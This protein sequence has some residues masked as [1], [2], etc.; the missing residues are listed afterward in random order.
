[1]DKEENILNGIESQ[2][3]SPQFKTLFYKEDGKYKRLGMKSKGNLQIKN[4]FDIVISLLSYCDRDILKSIIFVLFAFVSVSGF[5]Q[6]VGDYRNNGN[7][8]WGTLAT[9]QRWNGGAWQ[10]PTAGQ[11]YPGQ[12]TGTGTVIIEN[13]SNVTLNITPTYSINNLVLETGNR[14]TFIRFNGTNSL[15]V[16]GTTTIERPT[17]NNRYKYIDVL[18]G[19][20]T[21]GSIIIE[22]G[23]NNGRDSY[24]Q[25]SSGTVNVSGDVAMYGSNLRNYFLFSGNGTLN[26][27]GNMS[28]GTITN[29]M[30]GGTNPPNSG[31][32]NYN[33]TGAQSVGDYTY[34]NLTISGGNTKTIQGNVTVNNNLNLLNGNLSLGAG[35]N[36]ITIADGATLSGAFDNN[37][38]I[39]CNGNG[40]LIK[41]GNTGTDFE[42]VYPVGTG[43]SY[44]PFEITSM[45]SSGTGNVSVRTVGS[46]EPNANASDL[47]RYWTVNNT[48]TVTSANVSFGYANPGDVGSGDQ[49]TYI[50]YFYNGGWTIPDGI[51]AEGA[52]P[53]TVTGTNTIAGNWTSREA[54]NITTYYTYQSGNWNTAATWTTDPSGTLSVNPSVPDPDDRAIILNGR[55][56]SINS[57]SVSILSLQINEGGTLDI[58]ATTGHNFGDVRG[59]GLLRL[60]SNIFPSGSF[61]EFVSNNGGTV[62]YYNT[63]NF[64]LG[65]YTYNNLTLNLSNTG[66]I[67]TVLNNLT[68][69]GNLTI[70]QGTFR[71][72]SNT[73][74]TRLDLT[75][76][77]NVLVQTNGRISTGSGNVGSAHRFVVRGDFTNNGQ[78]RFSNLAAPDYLN[79]PDDRVDV[80]FDNGA[81][82]QNVV[83]N[84]RTEFYRIEINKGIDQTFV[85]NI[86]ATATNHFYLFGTNNN[87]GVTPSPDAPNIN[88]LNALGLMTGTVRLGP[89]IVLPSLAEESASGQDLNYHV[90]EDACLWIDGANVTHTTN[91]NGGNSNSFVLYGKLK[92][93]NPS[94]SLN[95]NN[96]HGI[97]LRANAA[98]HIENGTLTA[99]CIRTSTVAGT[100]R[101]SY[102]Q[103]GGTV[104][105][106]GNITGANRHPSFSMTW[107]A[108]GFVMS[109]GNLTI[110]QAT[111]GGD[112][113]EMSMV[114]GANEENISVTGGTVQFDIRNRNACFATTAP[115]WNLIINDASGASFTCMNRDYAVGT[116]VTDA[117]S[118]N[119]Q[120]LVVLNDFIIAN[121][122]TFI[123]NDEN[124]TLGRNF[125][126][127]ASATY[128]PGNNTTTFNGNKG[129]EFQNNGAIATGLFNLAIVENSNTSI[130]QNLE[131][132][133]NLTIEN[134]SFLQDMGRTISV[135]GN[136]VNSGTHTSQ[137]GGGIQL[138]GTT[139]Q[140]IGGSGSGVF[141]N[142]II[143]KSAGLASFT[144][145]QSLTGNLRLANGMLDIGMYNLS[146]G[147]ISN[148]YDALTG[149]TA[150]FSG[151]KMIRSSGN[152]S[153]GGLTKEYSSTGAFIFPIGTAS[154]Y[155]PATIQ[156]NAAPTTWGSVNVRPVAQYNPFVTSTNSLDYYWK[157]KQTGFTGIQANSVSHTFRYVD[158]DL[159]GRGNEANYVPGVYNPFS[160]AYINDISQVVDA[161]NDIRFNNVSYV[162]GDYTAG[163]LSAFQPITVF[164]SRQDG[165]WN[166][167]NTWST[168]AVGGAACPPGAVPGVNIPGPS[169]PVVIGDS[170]VVDHV[171]TVPVG[172]NNITIGG[173]QL[174]IGSTLDIT[175]TTGHNFGAIPDSK[176]SGS[177]LLK[178]SSALATAA[179][180]GGDFGNF[181]NSGGGSVEY[182]NTGVNFTLPV[183]PA[184]Y[185]NLTVSPANGNNIVL[186]N[187]DLMVYNDFTISGSG[188][189]VARL[190][191]GA[192]RILTV[193]GNIE[194]TGGSL[195]FRNNAIQ[196]IYAN[197]DINIAPGASFQVWNGGTAVNN[198]LYISGNLNNQGSFDMY[199]TAAYIC[200][201]YFTGDADKS[202]SG[203]GTN[204]FNYLNVDKGSSRN[205]VLNVT[206]NNLTLNGAGTALVL[207]NGTFRVSNPG[208]AF[209]L[210]TTSSFTIPTTAAL[211]VNEGTVNIGAN[212]N[213]GDLILAGRLEIINNG[214]V[215][216]GI[217][218]TNFNNDIEYASG[219]NP[220][221]MVSGN[222]V[223][224]VNGQVRRPTNI[225]TGALNYT[226]AGNSVVTID[227]RNPNN[228]RAM[229]EILNAGSS[230]NMSG[231]QLVISR[232]FNNSANTDL[233]LA[234]T[235]SNVTG[236]TL[237]L[238][239]ASAANG[240]QYNFVI[241][242]PV[243]NLVLDATTTVKT[244]NL[245]INPLTIKNDLT[246]E[247]NSVLNT[248]GLDVAI[249][250]DFINNNISGAAGL[251]AGGYQP[252]SAMQTTTFNGTSAQQITGNATN[253]TN[254]ANLTIATS[255]SLTLTAN[256]DIQVN[257]NL[258][259]SLGT[260]NDGGN[261]ID[262]IGNIENNANHL[263]PDATGGIVL[264]GTLR[265]AV[266]GNGN[267]A[268]GNIK[269]NNVL[270]VDLKDNSTINGVL[271]FTNGL[272]YIDDYLLTLGANATI[273]GS[274]DDTRMIMLNGVI[275]DAG[276]KKIFASG[277]SSFTFPMGVTGKYTPVTYTFTANSNTNASVT[278]KPV[279]YGHPI[280]FNAAGDELAYY[281]NVA[282]SGFSSAFTVDHTYQYMDADVSGTEASYFSGR[283]LSGSWV[284]EGGTA[285]TVNAGADQI[286][287]TA[288][289]FLDGEYTAGLTGNFSNK[290]VL[291]SIASGNWS[292]GDIWST[293]GHSGPA[294]SC[295]PDGHPV[296]IDAAHTITLD[297]DG[298]YAYAVNL[299]GTLN[300]G[301]TVFHNFGHVTGS[302]NFNLSSTADGVFVFPGGNY[303]GF[304]SSAGST[305]EFSGDNTAALP[306]KPGNNYK[307]YQNVIFSGTGAKQISAED[308]KVLG[309]LTISDGTT[310]DN[311]L[312]NRDITISGD[313]YDYNTSASGGFLPGTGKVIFRGVSKQQIHVSN[314]GTE[315]QFY[316][317]E[318]DNLSGVELSG[319]GS[320]GIS[321]KLYLTNG[322]LVTSATNILSISNSGTQ[323]VEGGGNNS[324]VD[325]PLRKM[326][327]SGSYF[328]YPVGDGTR[329][330]N[331]MLSSVSVTGYYLFEYIGYNPGTDGYDPTSRISPIDVV[332]NVEYWHAAGPGGATAH[333][334]V[335]WDN[336]SSIIPSNASSRQKLRVV[337]WNESAW[338]N[339]GNVVTD[340]GADSGL[341]RTSSAVAING[342]HYFTIG[343]ESL[344]TAIITSG[345]TGIC[346]DGSTATISIDLTGEAPWTIRYKINGSNETTLSNIAI[347]PY[348]LVVSN[349][350]PALNSGGPGN[351]DFNVSYVSDAT[352]SSGI[353]D[354]AK[355]VTITLFES[356][357]PAVSGNTT[358]AIGET[359]TYSTPN[360]SGHTYQ[361]TVNNGTINGSS[362]GSSVSITWASSFGTG[363]VRV[364][365]TATTGGCSKTT[366]NYDVT[367]TDVPNPLVSGNNNVCLNTTEIYRTA[368]V[369]THTYAWSLPLGGGTISGSS[370]L[371][372]VVVE[373][374][375][376]GPR[377]IR[378]DETGSSTVGNTMNLTVN[379]VPD[380]GNTITDPT[381]CEGSNASMVVEGTGPG[382]TYQL[383][384]NSDDTEVGLPVSSG[385]GGDIT[386]INNPTVTTTYNVLATNE[387][388]CS[389]QLTDL[390]IVTV[391]PLPS[392]HAGTDDEACSNNADV[393]LN[394]SYAIATGAIW[395]GGAGGFSPNA[396]TLNAVYTP[397]AAEIAAGTVSLVLS[398]TGN[399]VCN[400]ATDTMV[401]TYHQAPDA[402]I[403]VVDNFGT[404]INDAIICSGD[405]ATL[406]APAG[407]AYSWSTTETSQSIVVKNA[408]T[409]SVTVTDANNCSNTEDTVLTVHALPAGL[410]TIN[411]ADSLICEGD[412]VGFTANNGQSYNFILD[413]LSVQNST[414]ANYTNSS[415]LS[416]SY[417]MQV[418]VTNANA[419]SA[420]YNSIDFDV[421]L[422]PVTDSIYRKPNR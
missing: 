320:V 40:S 353:L 99:P 113:N 338:E 213:N 266:Y 31:T 276:V 371:D 110:N 195:E 403:S 188:T 199:T 236:G 122:S 7:G 49:T 130:T 172:F 313:W 288:T 119:A 416:G 285:G 164:Y 343:V 306:L 15:A 289:D 38:M 405:S 323:V 299:N 388:G 404:T 97:I 1:M 102:Y 376:L 339:R 36:N 180:P 310:F 300:V 286:N 303:N 184:N 422:V 109:G 147:A 10:T 160:W 333:V 4:G 174:N 87:M 183:A 362:T 267:G 156:I 71:I 43:T 14:A 398:T 227:G 311:T 69:N 23:T 352:G 314:A 220:E 132:R 112:G 157:V 51:S 258:T 178:I 206:A 83:L 6:S 204:D 153:D 277:A 224:F 271:E 37:R 193:E 98:I 287:L 281:W 391:D 262:V 185:N 129:Q 209:T 67:S 142:L 344:P 326:I 364:E 124:V 386:L 410:L 203:T 235:N 91:V 242:V 221:I 108:M 158:T 325:G 9:W 226:Q 210:S 82:D 2:C 228:T 145:D 155:T 103:S 231:G 332:S 293:V 81:S 141:G 92:I 93:T 151:T 214:V 197:N 126:I 296:E 324:F 208:L 33:G 396:N 54:P 205:T 27:G 253:L 85:L 282:S 291:Y 251:A 366:A 177:G 340:Y 346:D 256:T 114:I 259:I 57:G 365:E 60:Q 381:S 72:N 279:N 73:A 322:N 201:V 187:I 309:S 165:P 134:G 252:V 348:T 191:A 207:E 179:F 269:I 327:S 117:I 413:G 360:V 170:G 272:L 342:S 390:A 264:E 375:G 399:G 20:F 329:Y 356:P 189:G 318:I 149:T 317:L 163:E 355:T 233:Y 290:P 358:A 417:T 166:D 295:V 136:V 146:L 400:A 44:T 131:V 175:T 96:L 148:V 58:G 118:K 75:I 411:D 397:T 115:F 230:F 280:M 357:N 370:T 222:G 140:S 263:S 167:A 55:T 35:T 162:D 350:I 345:N 383:R 137:A 22:A 331:A 349:A 261:E 379:P 229:L 301:S 111:S 121:T 328:N 275:S 361:W 294:C 307:P 159:T 374:S 237:R 154:D 369:G 372:T 106:T 284:P 198:E 202:I 144:A 84:G 194:I 337:E 302:G 218:G 171:I 248:N 181:L 249:G 354:F 257:N 161:S 21:S 53:M 139:D 186:P 192:A 395:S 298:A 16:A 173:L 420:T 120:E 65:Q 359:V 62:E 56:V 312:F 283:Y 351:Y 406:I 219:G 319:A 402:S 389:V 74:T 12:N 39:V 254:F 63:A 59:Q 79:Y 104:T 89:N 250:G 304:L 150:V 116:G 260:L 234:P 341:I 373:W 247:G 415:L 244:S 245:R 334:T 232:N 387:Y 169:N 107:P 393:T 95:V 5:G 190:D 409:Y 217:A 19:T 77:G 401:I 255:S 138:N 380:N 414:S 308:L 123:A 419:C 143:N 50:P 86:D 273:A 305:I 28:G 212:N 278:V 52:N 88:N 335:R 297:A 408:A 48:V 418:E 152:M 64:T 412:A 125:S 265:Q 216:I 133:N 17:N 128:T 3:Q 80:V 274:L 377:S 368:K 367:I 347:S 394:G 30:G 70:K 94:S 127:H 90:D 68:V 239:S 101:G 176:I 46:Q 336:Q 241:S 238:G 76:E 246:I 168:V 225:T 29:T 34:H 384:L 240:S 330:G 215:N 11:G 243:W 105:I 200:N 66:T 382:I 100:H 26:V 223:L 78:A 392:A 61:T 321:G 385:P 292:N 42:M 196:T 407:M 13:N 47:Q 24:I 41:E 135:A 182:Y 45:V 315:E 18:A 316:H 32:V 25:I 378:V 270:N 421:V 211:S 8:N 363:W 268:F